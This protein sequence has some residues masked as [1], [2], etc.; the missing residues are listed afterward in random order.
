MTQATQCVPLFRDDAYQKTCAATVVAINDRGG[1]ILDQTV[2]YPTGGGQPGDCGQ[3]TWDGGKAD[4]ATTVKGDTSDEIVHGLAEGETP[5]AI[6]VVVEA[7]LDWAH[8][9]RLMRM[10]TCLHLLSSIVPYPVTGGQVG[11][12][13]GRLDFDIP[14]A[15]LDKQQIGSELDRLIKSDL[16]VAFRWISDAELEA[17]PNLVKTMSVKPPVGAGRVRL[18]EI[19]GA[20]L[21]PCGGTHVARTSEIGDVEVGKIEKKGRQNRRVNIRFCA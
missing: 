6:G 21:Q 18:V 10:H 17:Q 4:V 1:V 16:E 9:Y 14:E 2:F 11:V 5:P 12:E 3:L 15:G 7:S 20:D 13:K 19:P 8:R